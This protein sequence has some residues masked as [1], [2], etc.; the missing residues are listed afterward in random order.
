M[1]GLLQKARDLA[2]QLRREAHVA[3][4]EGDDFLR[5]SREADAAVI[6]LRIAQMEAGGEPLDVAIKGYMARRHQGWNRMWTV[7]AAAYGGDPVCLDTETGASWEYMG[8]AR[9][10]HQFR[11]RCLT[12]ERAY[13]T[14]VARA[15]DF[16]AISEPAT[17]VTLDREEANDL[18]IEASLLLR[19]RLG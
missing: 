10:E 14:V 16:D 1:D 7:L 8:T 11:H 2:T 4:S 12:G 9:G 3:A 6:D 13:A 19:H 17:P 15:E 18:L 5:G